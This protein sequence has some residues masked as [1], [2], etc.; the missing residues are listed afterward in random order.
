LLV[1]VI[2]NI[3]DAE[4]KAEE[5]KHEA[6]VDARKFVQDAELK[7]SEVYQQSLAAAEA[8]G[9]KIVALAEAEG[10][11]LVVPIQQRAEEEVRRVLDAARSKQEA[12]ISMVM[13]RIVKTYGHS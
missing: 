3:R 6:R 7:V 9:R 12:A 10:Q 11:G 1:E 8:E 2:K 5:T 4:Q 13:E